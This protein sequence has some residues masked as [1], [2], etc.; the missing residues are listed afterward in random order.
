[1][2]TIM[3]AGASGLP[4]ETVAKVLGAWDKVVL[5][6]LAR[7]VEVRLLGCGTIYTVVRAARQKRIFGGEP[8]IAPAKR[9]IVFRTT[10]PF[11]EVVKG[12]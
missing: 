5:A 3:V 8:Y 9:V 12:E 4:V 2:I 7:G 1:M 10:K 6:Q 11:D